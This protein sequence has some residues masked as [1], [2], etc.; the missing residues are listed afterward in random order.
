MIVLIGVCTHKRPQMLRDCLDSLTQQLVPPN[1]S[2]AIVVVDNESDPAAETIVDEFHH[3]SPIPIYYVHEPRRGIACARNAVLDTA[4]SMRADWIAMIDDDET[5][6]PDWLANLMAPEYL[7][8]PVLTGRHVRHYPTPLPFWAVPRH[9]STPTDSGRHL[10]TAYTGNVRFA[11]SLV[12]V[13]LRFDERFNLLGGEDARFFNRA[14][15][16]GF[17]IKQTL[18]AITHETIH[19]ERLTF[20]SQVYS[21]Y[22]RAASAAQDSKFKT[23]VSL[24]HLTH[25]ILT[26]IASPLCVVI[27]LRHFKRC[28]LL[29]ANHI[30]KALGYLAGGAGHRPTPYMDTVGH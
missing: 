2:A 23:R 12:N 17:S 7:D 18:R 29:G 22:C 16:L 30:A 9:G 27:G 4:T 13:G 25:G 26:M 8:V 19:R 6:Q 11:I 20:R 28:A 24:Y 21:S 10:D 14:R 15:A 5:A 3:I 1:I